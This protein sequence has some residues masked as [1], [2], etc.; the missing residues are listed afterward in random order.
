MPVSI[1]NW[2]THNFFNDKNDDPNPTEY[3]VSA[4]EYAQKR[5]DVAAILVDLNPDIAVLQEIENLAV[6]NDLN[7]SIKAAGGESY[8][9]TS[10]TPTYDTREISILSRIPIDKVIS[11]QDEYFEQWGTNG[12]SYKF[13]RDCVEAHLTVNGRELVL[14]GVHFRSKV[15]PDDPDK[16]LAEAQHARDIANGIVKAS[17]KAAI[18]VLGDYNDT[19]DSP[20]VKAVLGSGASAFS[21]AALLVPKPAQW[22]YN[23]KGLQELIDHQI[24]N[25]LFAGM[26]DAPSVVITHSA[27]VD[28]AS[29]HAPVMATYNV[30]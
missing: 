21:D 8:A 26:I 27:P 18:V 13:T 25:S 7:A 24:A 23:F 30:K 19:P 22:S 1:L 3:F 16:R 6:L 28:N 15:D 12:P 20:P 11:H 5:K 14:L 10:L 2:N 29:D 17:P 9:F 4:A